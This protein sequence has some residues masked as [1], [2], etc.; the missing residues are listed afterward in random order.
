MHA[1]GPLL[2]CAVRYPAL[3]GRWR[4]GVLLVGLAAGACGRD[5][6]A[7]ATTP[8]EV[9]TPLDQHVAWGRA[10]TLEEN[11]GVV[12]VLIRA[13]LDPRGGFLIADEQEN[14]VRRY[15]PRGRLL[16]SFGQ[17]GAGPR[18][19]TGLNRAVRLSSGDLV[20]IDAFSHGAVFDSAGGALKRTFRVPVS[21]VKSA[22][23]LN[24]S[25]LLLGG[26]L[27]AARG[28]DPE[29]R[30]HLWNLRA[31]RLGG[32]FFPVHGTTQAH[33][34]A[35]STAGLLG[36][37]VRGDTLAAVFALSDTVY[38]FDFAGRRA[39]TVPLRAEGLRRFDP[40]M[41]PP[42]MDMVSAREWFGRFSLVSDVYWLRD[43]SFVVQ[44]QDRVGVEPQWRLVHLARDGRRLF[45]SKD[46]PYLVAV[47]PATDELWFV[48]PGSPTPNA[49]TSARL[50]D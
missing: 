37:S 47:D 27:P 49:W 7:A 44:Y 48:R 29:A 14:Q 24:D 28:A 43:G 26:L 3:P 38:L 19:F 1:R 35:A 25:L 22:Y 20:A 18:E 17:R 11:D 16:F 39:G 5:R 31:N 23:L 10:I 9:F 8:R 21:P 30:L 36:A 34:F 50:R 41:R 4:L 13:S 40:S 2:T 15:D 12:N 45:E 6:A 42:H 32:S 46:T 33:R